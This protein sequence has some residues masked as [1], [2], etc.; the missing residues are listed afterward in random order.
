MKKI[1]IKKR[2]SEEVVCWRVDSEGVCPNTQI[3]TDGN[4]TVVV[5]VGNETGIQMGS[6]ATVHGLLNPGKTTKMFGGNKPYEKIDIFAI[7][8]SSEFNAEWAIAGEFAIPCVDPDHGVDCFA[9]AY[10][11]YCYKIINFNTF[12][13]TLSLDNN[14]EITRDFV[15][16]YLR[17]ETTGIIKAYLTG[18]INRSNIKDCQAR[19]DE[20][21]EELKEKI[22]RNLEVKGLSVYNFTVMKLSYD[23]RH[24][25][26]RGIVDDEK[27]KVTIK[28]IGNDGKLDDVAVDRAR[29]D[30][31]LDFY[32]AE[33]ELEEAK[34]KKGDV[35]YVFCSRCGEKN[36]MGNYCKKCG[37]KLNK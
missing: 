37:E 29:A 28:K 22:N 25:A 24:A 34:N 27:M 23:L 36:V 18:E 9:I 4:I 31:A 26:I 21:S 8:Q 16:E 6:L 20:I 5:K 35:E 33:K 12:L 1:Q 15:R 3:E 32:K 14:G 19:M 17:N 11:E 13:S 2:S 10:G 30:I 7:D